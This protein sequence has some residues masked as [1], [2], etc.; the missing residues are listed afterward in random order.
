MGGARDLQVFRPHRALPMLYGV[1]VTVGAGGLCAV[2]ALLGEPVLY[3]VGGTG[4]VLGLSML[5]VPLL[6]DRTIRLGAGNLAVGRRRYPLSAVQLERI[7]SHEIR[8]IEVLTFTIELTESD[9]S[10]RRLVVNANTYWPFEPMYQALQ[11]ALR[12]A[13]SGGS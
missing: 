9:G 11:Q 4:A 13:R 12:A 1:L 6:R 7:R 2:G 5:L 10:Q 8:G 3:L